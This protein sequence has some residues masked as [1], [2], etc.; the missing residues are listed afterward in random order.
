MSGGGGT[1]SENRICH[2]LEFRNSRRTLR[3]EFASPGQSAD[4]CP[5]NI[6]S[7][8][9]D[10]DQKPRKRRAFHMRTIFTEDS[11]LWSRALTCAAGSVEHYDHDRKT[12][13]VHFYEWRC[14]H[15]A[16][17]LLNSKQSA[18]ESEG[19]NCSPEPG[20]SIGWR[21]SP[22]KLPCIERSKQ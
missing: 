19:T 10:S 16:E 1:Y 15:T 2:N 7:A 4:T 9:G 21:Q 13:G 20:T 3:P 17:S 11:L 14:K 22:L 8:A 12:I 6:A 18:G 5:R